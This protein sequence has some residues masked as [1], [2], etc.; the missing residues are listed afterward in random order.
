MET[1]KPTNQ[2]CTIVISLAVVAS[3]QQ[4]KWL[5]EWETKFSFLIY[6]FR[7]R[8]GPGR[9]EEAE[10]LRSECGHGGSQTSRCEG[11]REWKPFTFIFLVEEEVATVY[12]LTTAPQ[13]CCRTLHTA[14][15]TLKKE[16]V[17]CYCCFFG[18]LIYSLI[19]FVMMIFLHCQK[20]QEVIPNQSM[21]Q[22]INQPFFIKCE[23]GMSLKKAKCIYVDIVDKSLP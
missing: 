15:K 16:K 3:R 13:Q 22:S 19:Y 23:M 17:F 11:A 12:P 6:R 4:H 5:E 18:K 20:P 1:S 7:L 10:E 9:A 8:A 2:L 21:N 14:G